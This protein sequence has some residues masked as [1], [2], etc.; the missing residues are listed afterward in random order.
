[1]LKYIV[2]AF[3]IVIL[4]LISKQW[5]F[6]HL[7]FGSALVITP[8][9]NIVHF[10]NTGAAFSFLSEAS[11]WQRYFFIV[12]SL[13][14]IVIIIRL[15]RERLK[16]PLLCLALAFILGGAIGNLCDRSYYGFVIDFIYV[17]YEVYYWPAFNVADSFIS[18][19]VS[20]ILY[21]AFKNKK[22]L[23]S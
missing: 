8:F 9:F 11:G 12:I 5:I 23:L 2:I 22:P 1:M 13:I 6:N 16:Q 7:D 18:I 3:L 19:G 10:Q 21:D 17:H 20:L 14:A 4:D 15:M